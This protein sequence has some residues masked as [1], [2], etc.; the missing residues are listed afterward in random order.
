[1]AKVNDV[2]VPE[3][4]TK[5]VTE[6]VKGKIRLSGLATEIGT[7][8]NTNEGDSITFPC[9]K[10]IGEAELME[11]GVSLTPETLNQTSLK[12]VVRHFG[13]S[14]KVFDHDEITAVGRFAEN[15][16]EQ[17]ATVIA[18]GRD[19]DLAEDIKANAVLKIS[20][21]TKDTISEA[22]LIQGFQLFGDEQDSSDFSAIVI[23]SRLVPSFYQMEGFSDRKFAYNPINNGGEIVDGVIGTYRNIPIMMTDIGT[24]D[25][26]AKECITFLVKKNALGIM[27]KKDFELE[28]QRDGN[29]KATD[30]IGDTYSAQGLIDLT[31]CVIIRMTIA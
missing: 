3:V 10:S 23:N 4:F 1:M 22:N 12:K 2:I 20:T 24:Y 27:P 15:A 18:R 19:K 8:K 11:K 17:I 29:M 14:V 9:F 28:L 5:E 30:V 31:G 25:T 6:R 13:K 16:A 7:L 21:P 26:T